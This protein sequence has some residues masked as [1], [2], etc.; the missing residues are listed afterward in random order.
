MARTFVKGAEVREPE[1]EERNK[2]GGG[3]VQEFDEVI[4]RYGVI[5]F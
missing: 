2:E 1:T 4:V 3:V 5:D